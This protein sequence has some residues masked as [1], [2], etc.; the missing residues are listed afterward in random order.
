MNPETMTADEIE[1]LVN[2]AVATRAIV[3]IKAPR[4]RVDIEPAAQLSLHSPA[5]ALRLA[6]VLRENERLRD[7]LRV[8]EHYSR[9]EIETLAEM[10]DARISREREAR[11]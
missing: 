11:P 7:L 8:A 2:A 4:A 1:A 3:D 5:L 10:R 6:K 9:N